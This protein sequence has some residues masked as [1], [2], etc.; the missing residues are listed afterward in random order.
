MIKWREII[1][2]LFKSREV[3]ALKEL[4]DK[5][6]INF[7]AFVEN[8]KTREIE[9][10]TREEC[11]SQKKIS[12]AFKVSPKEHKKKIFAIPTISEDDEQIEN[13]E[14]EDFAKLRK[15]YSISTE[16]KIKEK[17]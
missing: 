2:G 6:K 7:T 11:E 3:K 16:G 15:K 1:R 14:D 17:L 13:E 10:K 12:V 5:K 9:M 8:L 4:N